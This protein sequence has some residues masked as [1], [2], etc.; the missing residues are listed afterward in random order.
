MKNKIVPLLLSLLLT[1]TTVWAA[2]TEE[3]SPPSAISGEDSSVQTQSA[4]LQEEQEP[5]PTKPETETVPTQQ[6]PD[7]EQRMD[8]EQPT[9]ETE[10]E[11]FE[12]PAEPEAPAEQE[13]SADSQPS[14][15]PEPSAKPETPAQP[16]PSAEP[17]PS[18]KPEPTAEPEESAVSEAPAVSELPEEP[19]PSAE[20]AQPQVSKSPVESKSPAE[21]EPPEEPADVTPTPTI[22]P[23]NTELLLMNEENA[24]EMTA[25]DKA[26]QEML[27]EIQEGSML[28]LTIAEPNRARSVGKYTLINNGHVY[29][30]EIWTQEN[31]AQQYRMATSYYQI[32]YVDAEGQL[33][34]APAYCIEANKLGI[35]GQGQSE[36]LKDEAVKILT[37]ENMKK[38]LYF[39]WGGPGDIC[40]SFDP[41]CEHISWDAENRYVFTHFAL[42]KVYCGHAG[43]ATEAETQHV[44]LDRFIAYLCGLT[45]PPRDGTKLLTYNRDGIAEE[46]QHLTVD[47]KICRN[48]KKDY[49]FVWD[50]FAAGCRVTNMVYVSDANWENGIQITRNSGDVWQLAYWES[51][52]DYESRGASNPRIGPSEGTVTLKSGAYF[53]LI[54]PLM[55]NTSVTF[56]FTSILKPLTY[57]WLDAEEEKTSAYQDY[58]FVTHEGTY[59]Y[60]SL[61]AAPLPMGSL[62][63]K[64]SCAVSGSP[65][66]GAQYTLYAAEDI[67]SGTNFCFQKDGFVETC[68]TDAHGQSRFNYL[69]PGKYYVREAKAAPGYLLDNEKYPVTVAANHTGGGA[70]T[71]LLVQDEPEAEARGQIT[72]TKKIRESDIVWA[73]GNPTFFFTVEGTDRNG[74]K[75]Q[76]EDFVVFRPGNYHTDSGGYAYLSISFQQVPLGQYAIYEQ[77]AL[78]YY[79]K[80]VTANT[81][82][83]TVSRARNPAYG[84]APAQIATGT[85]ALSEAAP[86]AAITFVNEKARFDDYSHTQVVKNKIPLAW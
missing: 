14:Q 68:T 2:A 29:A 85:A 12:P 46:E 15:E 60:S 79:Q 82:N 1:A 27:E 67:Y 16:E 37:D 70:E 52:E 83:V 9:E 84:L 41:S 48:G 6:E 25:Q 44:G 3:I 11:E 47:L 13:P 49:P 55:Q 23:E 20:P 22:L 35:A 19:T 21:S 45:I 30:D 24:E 51:W 75:Q 17:E 59:G 64:K 18:A 73:H 74:K 78:R 61:T 63:L 72:V 65:V 80:S 58:G 42:S 28:A 71:V 31:Y 76:F 50:T 81:Q 57:L 43:Y 77:P 66:A 86:A 54:F 4:I 32:E 34:R 62:L 10:P 38:L 56:S 36:Q 8:S 26:S 53:Y 39:G 7:A 69:P 40:D 5:E 33:T